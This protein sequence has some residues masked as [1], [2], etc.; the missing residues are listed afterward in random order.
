[1]RKQLKQLII[2]LQQLDCN[3]DRQ[4]SSHCPNRSQHRCILL[5]FITVLFKS[6]PTVFTKKSD[7]SSTLLRMHKYYTLFP[8]H[9]TSL[10][11]TLNVLPNATNADI[12]RQYRKLTRQLHPDKNH[13]HHSLDNATDLESEYQ[14]RLFEVR[15]AYEVLKQ[16][17]TRLTYHRFGLFDT[18]TAAAILTGGKLGHFHISSTQ[19]RLMELMGY[20]QEEVYSRYDD[21]NR[22]SIRVMRIAMNLVELLRPL[23]EGLL[24]QDHLAHDIAKECDTLKSLPLGAHILRCI[25]RAY[26]L[27]G[28]RY[29]RRCRPSTFNRWG[30]RNNVGSSMSSLHLATFDL[31]DSL[32]VK[33]RHAKDLA[34]A[35]I[36]SGRLILEESVYSLRKSQSRK[37]EYPDL[38]NIV[39]KKRLSIYSLMRKRTN[40]L[41]Y[42]DSLG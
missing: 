19:A 6:V 22:H 1:M 35:A 26:R 4:R 30:I 5:I 23:V 32:Q 16:D 34:T 15:S 24:E 3:L 21:H 41:F 11:D 9:E 29:L 10:Y 38:G 36:A 28:Q 42:S 37:R 40:I 39:S 33:L 7:P 31:T 27:C 12:T 2:R 8:P 13:I 17:T 14:Q 20:T 25:G 18:G